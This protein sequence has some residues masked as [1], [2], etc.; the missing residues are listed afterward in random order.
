MNRIYKFETINRVTSELY[1]EE[2]WRMGTSTDIKKQYIKM[3]SSPNLVAHVT[4]LNPQDECTF[5]ITLNRDGYNESNV[6]GNYKVWILIKKLEMLDKDI[7]YR[8]RLFDYKNGNYKPKT[9]VF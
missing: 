5:I 1:A 2:Y 8:I 3:L 7:R 6:I 4:C 9:I